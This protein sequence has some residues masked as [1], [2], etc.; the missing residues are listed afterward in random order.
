MRDRAIEMSTV[1][2]S[3]WGL[4]PP[5]D[6][7][8]A[9][10]FAGAMDAIWPKDL[11]PEPDD[12]LRALVEGFGLVLSVLAEHIVSKGDDPL[13]LVADLAASLTRT[14]PTGTGD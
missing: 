12:D 11:A 1:L 8:R 6:V 10:P 5:A 9:H 4:L 2:I 14:P 3:S 7:D 13:A